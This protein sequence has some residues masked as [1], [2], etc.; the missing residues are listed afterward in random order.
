MT[1]ELSLFPN[2]AAAAGTTPL[3]HRLRPETLDEFYGHE[4][5]LGPG[6]PLRAAI[7]SG[8]V[9]SM[10][11]WGPPGCGKTTL[12]RLLA[13]YTDKEFVNFSAVTEG[14][15]RV[16]EII[17]EAEQRR[18]VE[19]RGTILFCDEIHRFNRAQQ[20]AFL[21]SVEAGVITL[22]GATT[23]NPSFEL[24]SA[25][26]SR[27]R[28]FVLEPLSADAIRAIV[29]RGW[30]KLAPK[31]REPPPLANDALD[32]LVRHAD[33]DA[34]RA[35]NATEALHRDVTRTQ[36][37]AEPG[38]A[39]PT[40]A[41][42]VTADQVIAVLERRIAQYDKSGE[43]HYNLISALH[44]AVRGSD[45]E[46]ALY[47][48]AR[49]VEGG[50]D[51]LYIARRV[52]RMAT[53]DIGLADPRALSITLAAKDA[54][55]FLGS[56][57]GEL[58]IAE[59]I[60][61]LAAA[62]KSNKVYAAWGAAQQAAR[63]Y[64]AEPVPL[65]IRNAPTALMKDLGYGRDYRYDHAEGGHAAGQEYLPDALRGTKWY[66][67]GDSGYEKTLAERLAWWAARKAGVKPP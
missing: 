2:E 65:H 63:D 47:W 8:S 21:P 52:V 50:E 60:V 16:R 10:V 40:T 57:E 48:F 58:A 6:K 26:L 17:R 9:S 38:T 44:K 49:M 45:V 32:L 13:R 5:L 25:L 15:P 36:R 19:G 66:E 41:D 35:L 56:P 59:A 12:A 54:Y 14:V 46:G 23:E 18:R 30:R 31:D 42:P 37:G 29:S 34:R 39:A 43:Q 27:L 3:A 53:E 24:N 67:P 64:P 55:D 61:Y 62:P 33:G 22:I 4:Q 7:E 28:V 11:L 51:V 20:D 1:T